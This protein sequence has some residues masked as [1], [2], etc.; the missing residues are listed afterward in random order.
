VKDSLTRNRRGMAPLLAIVLASALASG[1]PAQAAAHCPKPDA[2]FQAFLR[3]FRSDRAFQASRIV[4]PLHATDT[5][6]QNERQTRRLSRAEVRAMP[7]GVLVADPLASNSGD[8]ET[9][10]CE[11]RPRVR[12]GRATLLQYSCHSDLFG[13]TYRFVDRRGCWFL[14]EMR[15]SGG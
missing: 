4:Y 13:S 15:T 3:R 11:D 12:G 5:G 1:G 10:V 9:D 8:L 7:R 6:P 2:S 14:Q